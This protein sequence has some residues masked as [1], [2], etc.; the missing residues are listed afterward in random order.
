MIA[1]SYDDFVARIY[2][3]PDDDAL[4]LICADWFAE[5]EQVVE[6][7]CPR[8]SQYVNDLNNPFGAQLGYHPERDPA[9]GRHEGGWTNCKN[10]NG[11]GTSHRPGYVLQ[12][13]GFADRAEFIRLQCRIAAIEAT[14]SCGRCVKR[15]GGGQ[16]TNGPCVIDQERDD[17][18]DGRSKQAFLRMRHNKLMIRSGKS[19][20]PQS[21]VDFC[22]KQ[23]GEPYTVAASLISMHAL[24]TGYSFSRGFAEKVSLPLEAWKL[25]GPYIVR[26]TPIREVVLTDAT[27]C[28]R[29]TGT[30]EWDM[31]LEGRQFLPDRMVE[32]IRSYMP[33]QTERA[34]R[35]GCS[36]AAIQWAREQSCNTA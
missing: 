18:P 22:V 20:V 26:Q 6:T 3:D 16:H 30:Q 1:T 4:R 27:F 5:N 13:N 32:I 23:E 11:G 24:D 35:D 25:H 33:W 9:S 29:G 12:S 14:C 8:C 7:P 17:L 21:G 34:A 2:D 15:R 36:A 28:L 31:W 10:C 19:F